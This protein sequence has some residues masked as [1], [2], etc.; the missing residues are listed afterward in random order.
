MPLVRNAD[1]IAARIGEVEGDDFFGFQ[2]NDLIQYLPFDHAKRWLKPEA[3]ASDWEVNN[4]D[5]VDAAREYLPFAWDKANSNRGLSA[6]RSVDHMRAWLW[7]AGYD[8]SA[9][10]DERYE[11][12]G[13]PCLVVAS[14]LTGFDWRESDDG[15]WTNS[16]DSD[17]ISEAARE[18][19]VNDAEAFAATLQPVTA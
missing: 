19:R 16:E 15:R 5:P 14:T 17:G 3:V 8:V 4:A 7:L 10:F 12:Y 2:I 1:E 18:Q 6:S 9:D 13:K 11:F